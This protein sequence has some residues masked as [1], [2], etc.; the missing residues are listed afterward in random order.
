MKRLITFELIEFFNGINSVI[1]TLGLKKKAQMKLQEAF[2]LFI[3]SYFGTKKERDEFLT[4]FRK[5][6]TDNNGVLTKDELMQGIEFCWHQRLI[7]SCNPQVLMD[8]N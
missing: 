1:L 5:L 7:F 2:Y 8:I 4:T 3:C 6:D